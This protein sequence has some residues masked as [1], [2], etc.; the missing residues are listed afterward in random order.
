MLRPYRFT[1]VTTQYPRERARGPRMAHAI[2]PVRVARNDRE[3]T[4]DRRNHHRLRVGVNDDGTA[5]STIALKALTIQPFARWRPLHLGQALI[6]SIF[7][8]VLDRG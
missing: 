1:N 5:G 3:W 6:G 4:G 2:L 8:N 7:V